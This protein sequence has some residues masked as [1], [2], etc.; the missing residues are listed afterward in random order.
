[1][2]S[3]SAVWIERNAQPAAD[4]LQRLAERHQAKREAFDVAKPAA[5]AADVNAWASRHTEGRIKDILSAGGVPPDLRLMLTNAV[6]FHDRWAK[7][8]PKSATREEAFHVGP[9]A[10]RQVPMMHLRAT[11]PL[12]TVG[13]ARVLALPYRRGG[14]E[15]LLALPAEGHTLADVEAAVAS[16]GALSAWGRYAGPTEVDLA[17]PRFKVESQHNLVPPMVALGMG[18][19]F[20][21]GA[22]LS[23]TGV[24]DPLGPLFVSDFRQRALIE[25]DEQGTTAAAVTV[26]GY[27]CSPEPVRPVFRCDRPFLFVLRHVPT[28]A[29]LFVGRYAG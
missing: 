18:G 11:F 29:I 27:A 9:G 25:C 28:G 3:A 2:R 17:L 22:D 6:Y 24:R 4:Y 26:M 13:P 5:T 20:G 16:G 23:R 10:V 1:L 21:P 8:F 19:S 14:T 7:E 12:E 15:L